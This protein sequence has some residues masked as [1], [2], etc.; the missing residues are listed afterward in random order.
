MP[1]ITFTFALQTETKE[2]A[3]SGNV[4]PQAALRLLQQIV[5]DLAVAKA[6]ALEER[7]L[8]DKSKGGKKK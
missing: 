1:L 6:K 8:K 3:F 4:E 7:Q 5:I 2:A